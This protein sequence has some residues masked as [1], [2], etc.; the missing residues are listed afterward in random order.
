MAGGGKGEGGCPGTP[1]GGPRRRCPCRT[2]ADVYASLWLTV[3]PKLRTDST[4]AVRLPSRGSD[5][6]PTE[7]S[8][9]DPSSMLARGFPTRHE[10]PSHTQERQRYLPSV[11]RRVREGFLPFLCRGL[12]QSLEADDRRRIP[13]DA[14][15]RVR[16]QQRLGRPVQEY[17]LL[18]VPRQGTAAAKGCRQAVSA[19]GTVLFPSACWAR[20]GSTRRPKRGI[21]CT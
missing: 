13:R 4:A 8:A 20:R 19:P 11:L 18:P 6:T 10:T 17:H 15:H 2:F 21:C 5:A 14:N 12:E 9:R 16:H 1:R 3:T 7:K